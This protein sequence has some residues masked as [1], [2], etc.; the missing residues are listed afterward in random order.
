MKKNYEKAVPV[1]Q[2]ET[3]ED[4][5]KVKDDERKKKGH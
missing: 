4:K 1:K 2:Y 5:E 3:R